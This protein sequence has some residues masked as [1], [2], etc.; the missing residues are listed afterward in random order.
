M[1]SL[2]RPAKSLLLAFGS[3]L[4]CS[5]PSPVRAAT[6]VT[7][8]FGTYASNQNLSSAPDSGTVALHLT[9]GNLTDNIDGSGTNAAFSSTTNAFFA[10][11]N[12]TASAFTTSSYVS[13]TLSADPTY[14]INFSNIT[15]KL[16]ASSDATGNYTMNEAIRSSVDSYASDIQSTS[17]TVPPNSNNSTITFNSYNASLAAS[18]Y[19]N[20]SSIEFRFY[21]WDDSAASGDIV[22]FDELTVIGTVVPEPSTWA[23]LGFGAA[24]LLFFRLRPG[25]SRVKAQARRPDGKR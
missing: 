18:Q 11:S 17:I 8:M 3:L 1:L 4:L 5:V 23:L 22:R 20:V 21:F 9:A 19:Q 6:L 2:S 24:L 15:F 16:A 12:V 10:R 14:S 25:L 7:Y 13:F